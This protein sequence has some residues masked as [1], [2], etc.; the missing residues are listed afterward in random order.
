MGV[1]DGLQ[2]GARAGW[3]WRL[4]GRRA[5]LSMRATTR[6]LICNLTTVA[7]TPGEANPTSPTSAVTRHKILTYNP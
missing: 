2:K 7:T 1:R 4:P 5:R 3:C 6:I